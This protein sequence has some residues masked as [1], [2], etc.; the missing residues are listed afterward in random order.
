M[1]HSEQCVHRLLC[2]LSYCAHSSSHHIQACNTTTLYITA[3]YTH[4]HC[5]LVYICT[6]EELT[7]ETQ[8][9]L[10]QLGPQHL[11]ANLGEGLTG[12]ESPDLV[13]HFVEAVHSL[14]AELISASTASAAAAR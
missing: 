14:S 12:K 4:K 5:L 3:D 7:A 13:H 11:I 6:Q 9:M 1:R 8:A 2:Y 10:Q